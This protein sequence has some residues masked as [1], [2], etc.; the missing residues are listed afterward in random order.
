[1]PRNASSTGSPL[2]RPAAVLCGLA[3]AVLGAYGAMLV[4]AAATFEGDSLPGPL[5]LY[6]AAIG[7][8]LAAL[9]SAGLAHVLWRR[10]RRRL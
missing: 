4:Y 8:A 6:M 3:A 10:S 7:V 9:L 5:V 2:A 1:M